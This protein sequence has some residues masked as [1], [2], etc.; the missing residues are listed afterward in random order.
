MMMMMGSMWGWKQDPRS[1]RR[2]L[3]PP[4][5]L[6]LLPPPPKK[7]TAKPK[8]SPGSALSALQGKAVKGMRA[9]G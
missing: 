5:P 4:S 8:A 7:G 2:H 9:K 1:G 3:Q 6:P